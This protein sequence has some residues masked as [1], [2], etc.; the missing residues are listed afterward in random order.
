MVGQ[1]QKQRAPPGVTSSP[2]VR[3]PLSSQP[4]AARYR[5]ASLASWPTASAAEWCD[6]CIRPRF[7]QYRAISGLHREFSTPLVLIHQLRSVP[8]FKLITVSC[9]LT[10]MASMIL[11]ILGINWMYGDVYSVLPMLNPVVAFPFATALLLATCVGGMVMDKEE[12][13]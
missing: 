4:V 9:L 2:T 3:C 8:M 6:G 12:Q 7:R 13:A 1:G 5:L 10:G 11:F